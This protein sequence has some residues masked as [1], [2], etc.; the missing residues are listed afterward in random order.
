MSVGHTQVYFAQQIISFQAPYALKLF[1]SELRRLLNRPHCHL[2][3][4][5]LQDMSVVFNFIF[6][7]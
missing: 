5:N 3:P 6:W 7:L 1:S 4:V 2:L